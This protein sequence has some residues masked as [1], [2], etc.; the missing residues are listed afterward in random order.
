[1]NY[2]HN[3]LGPTS[4]QEVSQGDSVIW[5]TYSDHNIEANGSNPVSLTGA[6][7]VGC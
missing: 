3:L 7:L 2:V 4:S 1:M 5:D 6:G